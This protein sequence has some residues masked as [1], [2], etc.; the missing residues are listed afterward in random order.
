MPTEPPCYQSVPQAILTASR[1]ELTDVALNVLEGSLPAD[2]YGYCFTVGP[3]GSVASGGLPYRDGSPVFNGD[4]MVYRMDF[5]SP[6]TARL[7]TQLAKTPCFYAD[8]ATY[9]D[10]QYAPYRF[11]NHG[12]SR[13]S[14]HLGMRN[15]LNTALLPFRA[16]NDER[17]R[18]L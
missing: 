13:F 5:N 10:D 16:Q 9:A 14:L 4:G 6:G 3:T 8:R 17:D 7:T 12:L 18:L 1:V 15:Q 2:I 11:Q